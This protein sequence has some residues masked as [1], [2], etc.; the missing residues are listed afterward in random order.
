MLSNKEIFMQ[1]VKIIDSREMEAKLTA[2]LHAENVRKKLPDVYLMTKELAQTSIKLTKVILEKAHDPK[3][4]IAE[5]KEQNLY[6]QSRIKQELAENGF[7]KDYLEVNYFC[8]FCNDTGF[9]DN[10]RCDC[11]NELIINLTANEF[12]KISPL[13]L[14]SFSSFSLKFYKNEQERRQ[15]SRIFDFCKNY[16]QTFSLNSESIIMEGDTGL[17][18]TH[19]SLAIADEVIK[20]GYNVF[21]GSV[22]DYL[23]AIENEHFGRAPSDTNTLKQLL[24][25]DLLILDDLGVE[26]RSEFNT[27]TVHNI[28]NSRLSANKPTIINSNLTPSEINNKYSDR[29]TSRIYSNYQTLKFLG[30]D[31]RLEKKRTGEV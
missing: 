29:I 15:M 8:K 3:K 19:L 17:G 21:Y 14:C 23:N 11:L 31:I 30:N 28:I 13:K 4:K 9:I 24:N 25:C 16:A 12:N 7:P 1:A 18:K 5:I 2:Q 27:S 22:Q 26:F 6:I 10:K 20:K